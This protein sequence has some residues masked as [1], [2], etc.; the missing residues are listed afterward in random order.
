MKDEG[1]VK[2]ATRSWRWFVFGIASSNFF[3][4]QFYRAS[5]A[6]IAPQLIR[7][8]SLSTEE[9]GLLSAAFFYAFALT[10]IPISMTLD[11]I[12]PRRL[13][14]GLSLLGIAGALIFSLADSMAWG[15]IGRL[16]LGVG[17]A[18]NLMGTFKLL[19]TWFGPE[20]FATLSGIVFS[21]GTA[22]NMSATT[23]LVLMVDR[24]GWRG[25]FQLI[26]AVNLLIVLVFFLLVRDRPEEEISS[27]APVPEGKPSPRGIWGDLPR[28][29]RRRDYWIISFGT[30]V[31]YGVFSAFQNLWAGPFLMD[32]LKFSPVKSGNAIFLLNLGMLL[33]GPLMGAASDRV[34]HGRKWVVILGHVFLSFTVLSLAGLP[35]ESG[36]VLVAGLFLGF[37]LFRASGL[38]M[39]P[40]IKD[41]MPIEMA[42]TAMTGINFFTMIGSAAFL[43]GL[44]SLMQALYPGAS[45]GHDAFQ[46]AFILCGVCLLGV[47]VLYCFTRESGKTGAQSSMF[48][49]ARE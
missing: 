6:V 41:L 13:M 7:D 17:M 22:G 29:F 39:Y 9:L 32:V 11:R 21:I 37:G 34:F 31:S 33:G 24:L 2:P 45:R 43:H 14:T 20:R 36:F 35:V 30:F 25:G 44:G 47:V 23:P 16:L 12:G 40:H 18:C 49:A 48:K 19:T 10:Q 8:L 27:D 15:L 1:F 5:N 3:L 28:L 46:A 42:G 38:L 4:S 26:A